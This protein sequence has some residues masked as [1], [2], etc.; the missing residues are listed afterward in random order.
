M[1]AQP[2]CTNSNKVA[3]CTADFLTRNTRVARET[4]SYRVPVFRSVYITRKGICCS[5]TPQTHT[6]LVQRIRTLAAFPSTAVS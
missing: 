4:D 3:I 2:A 1:V 5:S 6:T